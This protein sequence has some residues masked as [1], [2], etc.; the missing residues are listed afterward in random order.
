[1]W[2]NMLGGMVSGNGF[3]VNKGSQMFSYMQIRYN[4]IRANSISESI[5]F[6]KSP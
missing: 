3:C 6:K 5:V 4:I 1:M 2:F